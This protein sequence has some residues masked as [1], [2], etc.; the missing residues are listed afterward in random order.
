MKKINRKKLNNKGFT[1][2][3]LLA[4]V[5]ILAVVM[6]IALTNVLG[7]MNKARLGSVADSAQVVAKGLTQEYAESMVTGDTAL[8]DDTINLTETGFYYLPNGV[9][10]QYNLS[11]SDYDFNGSGTFSATDANGVKSSFAHFDFGSGKFVVC[12]I[13]TSKTSKYWVENSKNDAVEKVTVAEKEVN[14]AKDVIYK[15]SE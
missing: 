11:T 14:I 4:V 7:S 8:Y 10:N 9:A 3:E 1:L 15:C 13:V 12:L 2:I 6:G 5:V